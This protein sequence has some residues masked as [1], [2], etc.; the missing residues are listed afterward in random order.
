[1]RLNRHLRQAYIDTAKAL[2]G[3]ERRIFMAQITIA[4]GEGGQRQAQDELGWNRGTIRKGIRELR[5]EEIEEKTYLRGR[6]SIETHFPMLMDDIRAIISVRD[7]SAPQVRQILIEEMG[8][9]S[10]TAPSAET[11]RKRI[12]IIRPTLITPTDP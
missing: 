2:K 8:Y 6:K 5:G 7:C 10:A 1:M 11:I 4:L 3:R 12:N 9:D